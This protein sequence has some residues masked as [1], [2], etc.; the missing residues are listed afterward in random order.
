MLHQQL[1]PDT[2]PTDL[3]IDVVASSGALAELRRLE[4]VVIPLLRVE[5]LRQLRLEGRRVA[6]LAHLV[7]NLESLA[8]QV[9]GGPWISGEQVDGRSIAG[10]AAPVEHRPKFLVDVSPGGQVAASLVESTL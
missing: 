10:G 8:K 2:P 6:R 5:G 7:E 9:F 4:G 3:R 1:R